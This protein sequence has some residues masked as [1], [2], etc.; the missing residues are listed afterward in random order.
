MPDDDKGLSSDHDLLVR[1]DERTRAADEFMRNIQKSMVTQ[2]EFKPVKSI[3]YG[4][5]ALVGS[6]V[7]I[8]ILGMII[9]GVSK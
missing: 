8:A 2:A 4:A 7:G 3:V 5:V 6:T 1:I 9:N